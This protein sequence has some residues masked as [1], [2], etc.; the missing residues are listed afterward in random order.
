MFRYDLINS[1]NS[2]ASFA[3]AAACLPHMREAGFGHIINQS[4]PIELDKLAGMTAYYIS[5]FGMTLG[6][7][8]IAQEYKGKGVAANSIWPNTLI[9]S[10]ATENHA[11]GEPKMWRKASVLTDAIIGIMSQHPDT[12]SGN[13]FIDEH[14]LREVMGETNFE[15]YQCVPGHEPPTMEQIVSKMGGFDAGRA[16]V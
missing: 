4:P 7:L 3:L 13:Q 1:I 2:R 12:C 8:G 10:S 14:F 6:A 5:K 9:E 16:K 11:L 15:Q